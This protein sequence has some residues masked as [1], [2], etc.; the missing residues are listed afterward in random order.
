MLQ[1]LYE[2]AAPVT[3]R[4]VLTGAA[5]VGQQAACRALHYQLTEA[6]DLLLA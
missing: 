1:R 4:L 5:D 3:H 2:L 6:P